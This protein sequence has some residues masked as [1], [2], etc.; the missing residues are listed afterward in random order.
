LDKNIFINN[1]LRYDVTI[2]LPR[3]IWGEYNKTHWHY[4]P[5]N[6]LWKKY[7]EIYE[8]IYWNALF[9]QQNNEVSYYTNAKQ[10]DKVIMN[11]WFWHVTINDSDDILV[12]ANIVN[13]TFES[14]YNNYNKNNWANYIYTKTW[15]ILNK[16][17][18]NHINI[19]QK[20]DFFVWIDMYNDFLNNT[21]KFNFLH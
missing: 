12:M 13:D 14:E 18:H 19:K 21:E 1:Y 17:Y 4:H 10:W 20:Q 7:E 3:I 15:F 5:K 2:I 11:E 9:L 16:N 8:V 6:S